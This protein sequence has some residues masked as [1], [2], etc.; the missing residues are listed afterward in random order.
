MRELTPS[1]GFDLEYT[2]ASW[3]AQLSCQQNLGDQDVR[4]LEGHLR[5]GIER[6]CS[7]GLTMEEAFW[8]TAKRLGDPTAL[9]LEFAKVGG[10]ET[11]MKAIRAGIGVLAVLQIV[12]WAKLIPWYPWEFYHAVDNL[13]ALPNYLF[14]AA[15]FAGF[16][17]AVRPNI[18]GGLRKITKWFNFSGVLL[19]L[20]FTLAQRIGSVPDRVSSPLFVLSITAPPFLLAVLLAATKP[21]DDNRRKVS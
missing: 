15:G 3:R 10:R 19:V 9:S 2:I 20:A 14:V 8:V 13:M 21:M 4:E 7:V 16:A 17:I 11:P 5:D 6:L 18:F 1:H 12:Y